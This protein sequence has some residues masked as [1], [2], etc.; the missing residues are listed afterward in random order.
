MIFKDGAVIKIKK[1]PDA[2][3]NLSGMRICT[4]G[5]SLK[6]GETGWGLFCK[7]SEEASISAYGNVGPDSTN[8][9]AEILGFIVALETI[10][11]N[12]WQNTDIVLDSMYV[13]DGASKH[14]RK[15][16]ARE[17]LT[18]QGKDVKN[19]DLWEVVILKLDKL[20]KLK[21]H[22]SY[23]WV[24]GHSGDTGNEAADANATLG[25]KTVETMREVYY[26]IIKSK[27]SKPKKPKKPK[28]AEYSRLIAGNT[29]IF[30]TNTEVKKDLNIYMMLKYDKQTAKKG[31]KVSLCGSLSNSDF[32]GIA[33]TKEPIKPIEDIKEYQSII[34]SGDY[35]NPVKINWNTLS[36][37]DIWGSL[38]KDGIH[39]LSNKSKHIFFNELP[40]T[41]Y[42]RPPI[43]VYNAYATLSMYQD[44]LISYINND[45]GKMLVHDVSEAFV[46]DKGKFIQP[47]V[48]NNKVYNVTIDNQEL[49]LTLGVDILPKLN[50]SRL[51]KDNKKFK[52]LILQHGI[53]KK[54]F[55]YS[56]IIEIDDDY[57][58]YGNA[59]SNVKH[60]KVKK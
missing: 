50:L 8:N 13:L 59:L 15:W 4:D 3:Q 52:V 57:A 51:C 32:Y 25:I 45:L 20:H 54:T 26:E 28:P 12:K 46:N 29:L 39:V 47:D 53:T 36:K 49:V 41:Q 40:L 38:D 37:P 10:I 43:R 17:W 24:K 56:V 34:D 2:F 6:T 9:R 22:I 31:N 35:V 5:G 19:K 27:P 16:A 42:V 48:N 33:M 1:L 21:L 44:L 60:K 58:I 23:K 55:R 30:L 11:I 7:L 14:V 18:V